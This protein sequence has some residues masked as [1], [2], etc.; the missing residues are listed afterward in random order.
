MTPARDPK[1]SFWR[2]S[3][4]LWGSLGIPWGYPGGLLGGSWGHPWLE[5]EFEMKKL[6]FHPYLAKRD[7]EHQIC[8]YNVGFI[9]IG[10]KKLLWLQCGDMG[11]L[12]SA[13]TATLF[14][15]MSIKPT[16]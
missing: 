12:R 7:F 14:W 4:A 10:E 5:H 1:L 8:Q 13:A 3:G 15:P 9:D 16:F 2:V 6:C 11:D